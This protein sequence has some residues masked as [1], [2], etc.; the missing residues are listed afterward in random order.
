MPERT[1]KVTG[2]G[3]V[4]VKPDLTV[5]SIDIS[6]KEKEYAD[7]MKKSV[8]M[9]GELK[10]IFTGLG[11][12]AADVKTT[13]FG[14]DAVYKAIDC[15][16]KSGGIDIP[17]FLRPKSGNTRRVLTGYEFTHSIK[18]EFDSDNELLGKILYKLGH[19]AL[20][21]VFHIKFTVKDPE[22]AKNLLL[23]NAVADSKAKAEIITKAAGVT[24]GEILSLDYSWGEI[25]FGTAPINRMFEADEYYDDDADESYDIDVNPDDIKASDSV[26]VTWRIS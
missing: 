11:F 12:N 9:T 20:K 17:D 24:L 22:A 5:I 18:V 16:E 13:G 26:T 15:K 6:G 4:S 2:T 1:I 8:Q 14:I 19:S 21:P 7:A 25:D 23:E 10:D 3:K